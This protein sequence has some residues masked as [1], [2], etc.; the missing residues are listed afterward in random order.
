MLQPIQDTSRARKA[1]GNCWECGGFRLFL[2]RDHSTPRYLGGTDDASNIQWLCANCH[3]DKSRAESSDAS[4]RQH[5]RAPFSAEARARMSLAKKGKPGHPLSWEQ[6][7]AISARHKGKTVSPE[8][9]ARLS[10]AL[11]GK[12]KSL[13]HR[14]ALRQPRSAEQCKRIKVAAQNRPSTWNE[15]Q[16]VAQRAAQVN[17]TRDARGCFSKGGSL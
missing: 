4:R 2:Q 16:R 7:A 10:L 13:E 12:K 9:R 15:R 17:R 11:R 6:R 1:G 3:E 8:T 5:K 14:A